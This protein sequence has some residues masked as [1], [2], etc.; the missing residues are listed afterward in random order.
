MAG[1]TVESEKRFIKKNIGI[2]N[3][4]NKKDILKVVIN[5]EGLSVAKEFP[6][7]QGITIDLDAIKNLHVITMIYNIVKKRKDSI[8]LL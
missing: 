8:K 5:E 2:L 3:I 4:E 6:N 1:R 7:K